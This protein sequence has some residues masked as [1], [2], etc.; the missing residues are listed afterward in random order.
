MRNGRQGPLVS[1]RCFDLRFIL[2]FRSGVESVDSILCLGIQQISLAVS[3][4]VESVVLF[5]P[6]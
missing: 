4:S 5:F 2:F 6:D 3:F 1:T